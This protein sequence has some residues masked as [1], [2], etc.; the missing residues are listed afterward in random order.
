MFLDEGGDVSLWEETMRSRFDYPYSTKWSFWMQDVRKIFHRYVALS[1]KR[2]SVPEF[3][4]D[5]AEWKGPLSE[6]DQPY[7]GVGTV[8][9]SWIRTLFADQVLDNK[10]PL[11]LY[12]KHFA[13]AP[14]RRIMV[15]RWN[16]ANE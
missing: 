11:S 4:T 7:I 12:L 13:T 9:D 6:I 15:L 16:S 2:K 3:L 14:F 8:L 1:Q 10:R 5:P